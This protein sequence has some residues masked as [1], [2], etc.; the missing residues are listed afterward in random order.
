MKISRRSLSAFLFCTI[1]VLSILGLSRRWATEKAHRQ[2]GLVVETTEIQSLARQSGLAP[3]AFLA[4]LKAQGLQGVAVNELSGFDMAGGQSGFLYG[5]LVRFPEA[6]RLFS[7]SDAGDLATLAISEKK[8]WAKEAVSYLEAKFPDLR[9]ASYSG[10]VYILIPRSVYE[11][12]K[13]GVVADFVGLDLARSNGMPVLF[14]PAPCPGAGADRVVASL[15]AL[16]KNRSEIRGVLPQGLFIM[17]SPDILKIGEWIRK[18]G[19][20]LAQAEFNRQLGADKLTRASYPALVPIHSVTTDEVLVKRLSRDAIVERMVRASVERSVPLLL[21]RSYEIDTGGRKESFIQDMSRIK[22]DLEGRG[23]VAVWPEPFRDWG[24]SIMGA[25]AFG[26]AFTLLFTRLFLRFRGKLE[27]NAG[28]VETAS[29]VL[30][31]LLLAFLMLKV[32]LAARVAGAVGSAMIATEATLWTLGEYRKPIRGLMGGLVLTVTG[33]LALAAFFSTPQTMLRL[34]PFSG[35]KATLLL[36]PILVL[37]HD[38]KRRIYPE[39]FRELM[40][41]PMVWLEFLLVCLVLVSAGILALRSDNTAFV[42][43]WERSLRDLLERTLVARPRTKELF[44]GYPALILWFAMARKNWG[45]QAWILPRAAASIGFASA[46]NSFCHFHTHL[47]FILFRVFNG[48]W[49]GILVGL[50]ALA[51]LSLVALPLA[52][53]W[54]TLLWP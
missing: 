21:L 17:G 15:D 34:Q 51:F 7:V 43:G 22:N 12:E 28:V 9:V 31:G 23:F 5:P 47:S 25:L 13:A 39:G 53:R 8:T 32:S 10:M 6:S 14:R 52:R 44:I 11:L 29:V 3:D 27:G 54:R 45:K 38:L 16:L 49:T 42:G 48:W 50:A 41:R 24:R 26:M 35:V 19:L 18:K 30:G 37:A 40:L 46:V 20:F 33:G 1:L 4:D 2:F 36:P